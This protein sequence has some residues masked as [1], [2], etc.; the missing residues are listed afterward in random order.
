MAQ[1]TTAKAKPKPNKW[2]DLVASVD[3]NA[4]VKLYLYGDIGWYDIVAADMI[5]ALAPHA[6]KDI[7][8][9]ILSDGGEVWEGVAIHGALKDHTGKITGIIDSVCASISSLIAMACDELFIRPF[10][11]IMIHEARGGSYGSAE[12]LRIDAAA[13][14]E[15]NDAMAEAVA[16]KTGKT[17]EEIRADMKSD[18]WLR[19]QAA[20]D[21]GICDG[22]YGEVDATPSAVSE[23]MASI[24]GVPPLQNLERLNAPAE[25]V[26][27]FGKPQQ[28]AAPKTSAEPQPINKPVA[29]SEP[30]PKG[31]NMTE[32]EK[33]ALLAQGKKQEAQRRNG[34][35]ASFRAHRNVPGVSDILNACLDDDACT[36]E[37]ANSKLLAHLAAAPSAQTTPNPTEQSTNAVATAKKHLKQAIHAQMGAKV[38]MDAANPYR[39]M[40]S[41]ETV[42]AAMKDMGRGDEIAGMTKDA[43][44]AHAFNHT[45][46]DFS[47]IFTE[48]VKL[49]IND[50][51]SDVKPWHLGFVKRIPMDFGRPN[52]MIKTSD[53]SSLSIRTENGEFKKVKL[54]ASRDAMWLD[55]Y[56]IEIGVTRELL[57]SDQ[58][59]LIKSEIADYVR[60]AQQFPQELLLGM[61]IE[62]VEMND[63]DPIFN[64]KEGNLY[65]G[66]L[67]ATRIAKISG[68]I[69]D[70]QSDKGRSLGLIPQAVLSSG[71]ERA[72]IKAILSAP[73]INNVPNLAYEAFA[74]SIADGML[75]RTGKT[76]F[77]ANAKHT[78][79][80]EGYNK[81]HDGI[82]VE[83]KTPWVSDGMTVRI[84]LDVAMDVVSRKGLKCNDSKA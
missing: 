14:D 56:G 32:E 39:Y 26:E 24:S 3:S 74:E 34:I 81:D 72:G 83:T 27:M 31:N 35:G 21:Y 71:S 53:K 70:T 69:I 33:Q 52:G 66:A 58:L 64:D 62:N 80:I 23:M 79:I 78:S 11:Q 12:Q 1:K 73:T 40:G 5:N 47:E 48:G 4:P 54:E 9:H 17:V 18:F 76:F 16:S 30:K 25:L 19:G 44:V 75:A 82:Q 61:L 51:M 6:G 7:E 46:S 10:A 63:G 59:G 49:I 38:E 68:D 37:M 50:E 42:R 29:G 45:T 43:L 13:F 15:M 60:V 41:V 57:Q 65:K 28:S 22:L 84:W 8:L 36:V 77:L 67:D 2:F 20:V 55:S